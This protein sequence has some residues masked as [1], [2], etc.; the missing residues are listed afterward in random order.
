E[1]AIILGGVIC[2]RHHDELWILALVAAV[3]AVLGGMT[4]YLVGQQFGPRLLETRVMRTR[5]RAVD[6]TRDFLTRR[7]AWAVFL[8]RFTPFLR[9]VIPGMAGMSDMP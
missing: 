3:A 5:R 4:G 8:C 6:G 2:S 7:G 9:A 1:T